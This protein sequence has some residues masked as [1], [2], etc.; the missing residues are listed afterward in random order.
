MNLEHKAAPKPVAY[1]SSA[2]G[3][4]P[5]SYKTY[6]D[7]VFKFASDLREL[8]RTT[9]WGADITPKQYV[10]HMATLLT[11]IGNSISYADVLDTGHYRMIDE[12]ISYGEG[13]NRNTVGHSIQKVIDDSVKYLRGIESATRAQH[14][15][16]NQNGSELEH[17]GR[18]GMKWGMHIFGKEHVYKKSV[19][20]LG[21]IDR[22][23]NKFESQKHMADTL[24]YKNYQKGHSWFRNLFM[25]DDK[26]NQYI[27]TAREYKELSEYYKQQ[28]ERMQYIGERLG[29]AMD[30][31]LG[32][33][34]LES[35]KPDDIY[36]GEKYCVDVIKNNRD[37]RL[38]KEG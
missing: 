31:V 12:A 36:L 2:S 25:S 15:A 3:H 13:P 27:N 18:L 10:S 26:R 4:K 37:I 22:K 33:M 28:G 6:G 32:D 5:T 30:S 24:T 16:E 29:D 7:R 23:K 35:F 20:K 14:S 34:K 11:R 1:R 21:K 17:Y 19:R 38:K 9:T 8:I